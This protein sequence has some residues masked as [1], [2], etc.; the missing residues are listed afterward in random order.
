MAFEAGV[1]P[2]YLK[3]GNGSKRLASSRLGNLKVHGSHSL[4]NLAQGILLPEHQEDGPHAGASSISSCLE[5]AAS[6]GRLVV[7]IGLAKKAAGGKL[8]P[9]SGLLMEKGARVWPKKAAGG[10]GKL[11]ARLLN[12]STNDN[13]LSE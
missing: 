8:H 4:P 2:I 3:F 6:K 13:R 10:K 9:D 12:T 7:E 5:Q 11:D 1:G